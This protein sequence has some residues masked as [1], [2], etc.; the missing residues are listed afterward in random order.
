MSNDFVLWAGQ[1]NISF[2]FPTI[3]FDSGDCLKDLM[4]TNHEGRGR[5][6]CPPNV[7]R[8]GKKCDVTILKYKIVSSGPKFNQLNVPLLVRTDNSAFSCILDCCYIAY[9]NI[10]NCHLFK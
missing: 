2:T 4:G 6:T 8:T 7:I 3:M 10:L 9:L 5:G 1:Q